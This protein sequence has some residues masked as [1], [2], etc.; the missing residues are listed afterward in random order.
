MNPL[1]MSYRPDS[2]EMCLDGRK[3]ETR[4]TWD[5]RMEL[6][7]AKGKLVAIAD[8]GGS[9]KWRIGK[10]IVIKP[11]RTLKAV[12]RVM[13]VGLRIEPVQ[14]ITEESARLE[15]VT[16]C[17]LPDGSDPSTWWRGQSDAEPCRT[18]RDAYSQIWFTLYGFGSKSWLKNPLVIAIKFRPLKEGE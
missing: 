8:F 11:G 2:A 1:I 16:V 10:P 13:C 5:N 7:V 14:N 4:R 15:G 6:I 17:Q 12:G 3:R 9:E 18:A